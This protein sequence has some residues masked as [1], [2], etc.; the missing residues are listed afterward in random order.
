[1]KKWLVLVLLFTIATACK[2][3]HIPDVSNIHVALEVQRFDKDF[4]LMDTNHIETSLT[5]IANKYPSFSK[6]FLYDILMIS[7]EPDSLGFKVKEFIK[8]YKP[9]YDSVQ[10]QFASFDKQADQIKKGLQFTG[11]YFPSYKLPSKVITYVGPMEGYGNV[12]TASG[13]AVGLQLCL[14]GDF[15]MYHSDYINE[16]Y[17][18]YVSKRFAPEYIVVNCMKN[19]INDIYPEKNG[20]GPLAY[21]MIESG[22]RLYMLDQLLPETADTIKTGYTKAQLDGCMKHEALIWNFF[23]QNNLLYITDPMQTKD[24][25]SDGP[26]TPEL[27]EASPGNIGQFIGW[28]IIQKWMEEHDKTTLQQ[29]LNTPAKQIFEEAKYKP[30]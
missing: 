25:L 8:L 20:N 2:R 5:N 17:P 19:I 14:G 12:L 10:L 13:L 22:K 26:S 6:D 21:Q 24:Y 7:P 1:M 30:S 3:K 16:V 15:S 18:G 28:M 11:Y 29:L 4:F 9:V 23:L 27:G